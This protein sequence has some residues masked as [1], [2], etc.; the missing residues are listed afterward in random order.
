MRRTA[1]AVLALSPTMA[2]C[3]R[4]RLE[5]AGLAAD[6]ERHGGIPLAHCKCNSRRGEDERWVPYMAVAFPDLP[7]AQQRW[8]DQM[9]HACSDGGADDHA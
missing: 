5:A 8:P 1:P 9:N 3:E 6:S 2:T 7:G 4:L